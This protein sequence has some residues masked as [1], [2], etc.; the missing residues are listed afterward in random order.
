MVTE[1]ER[2]L[3]TFSKKYLVEEEDVSGIP[4]GRGY[5]LKNADWWNARA[6]LITPTQTPPPGRRSKAPPMAS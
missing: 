3:L 1:S 6:A 4:K 2:Q 5:L